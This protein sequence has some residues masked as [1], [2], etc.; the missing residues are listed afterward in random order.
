[1][2]HNEIDLSK[3]MKVGRD[4]DEILVNDFTEDSAQEFRDKLLEAAKD[5]PMKPIVVYID[6][7]GGEVDALAKMIETMDEVSNPVITVAMGKAMSCGAML[8]SHGDIRFCGKHSR[9]MIHEVSI[10]TGGDVH[11]VESTAKEGQ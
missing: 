4:S 7:Y 3:M 1:M 9:V 11:D 6:S 10:G 5:D 2:N 8:L